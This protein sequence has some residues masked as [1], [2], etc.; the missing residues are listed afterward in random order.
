M[1]L[2]ELMSGLRAPIL[3]TRSGKFGKSFRLK[4]LQALL[5]FPNDLGGNSRSSVDQRQALIGTQNA[6]HFRH[7]VRR[8]AATRRH[9][10]AL[11]ADQTEA[12]LRID[13]IRVALA[14]DLHVLFGIA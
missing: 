3:F 13:Y 10:D 2:S 5:R 12:G 8:D 1:S 14:P 6:D 11:P 4:S 9:R 7:A